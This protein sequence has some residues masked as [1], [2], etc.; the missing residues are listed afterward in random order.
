MTTNS[1]NRDFR[2]ID[3]LTRKLIVASGSTIYEG[4]IVSIDDNGNAIAGGSTYLFAGIAM[5]TATEN[6]EVTIMLNVLCR[7]NLTGVTP[8]DVGRIAYV[9]DNNTVTL[10]KTSG[11]IGPLISVS[12]NECY[13]YILGKISPASLD[14]PLKFIELS[15]TPSTYLSQA[16]KLLKV[17]TT[18]D[19]IE[20]SNNY[21]TKTEIDNTLG[22]YYTKTEVDAK[23]SWMINID[24]Q[25]YNSIIQGTWGFVTQTGQY[26]GFTFRNAAVDGDKVR[27]KE[28]IPA[29]TY[30][31]RVMSVQSSARGIIKVAIDNV[32]VATFDGY[33]AGSVLNKIFEQASIV[34][35]TTGIKN[36]DIYV[37][38][39]NVSSSN[40][41][42]GYNFIT[43]VRTV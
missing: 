41:F 20:F 29:G 15:D 4:T 25:S 16:N 9:V 7:F 26:T 5:N 39:K 27:Y 42:M 2:F 11:V 31:L 36:I 14:E 13:I 10:A 22:D 8:A 3:Y 34:I 40:Y 35:A 38:G 24:P 19:G 6:T 23:T 21:Y 33:V 18:E 1:V 12:D 30:T 37:D 32:V 43:F 17:K 28:F